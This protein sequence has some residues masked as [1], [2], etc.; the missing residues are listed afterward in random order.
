MS[1]KFTLLKTMFSGSAKFRIICQHAETVTIVL[2][3]RKER[4]GRYL[5][6]LTSDGID[7]KFL[8]IFRLTIMEKRSYENRK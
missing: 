1:Y 5:F 8:S 3:Y 2:R 4:A 6:E 7:I